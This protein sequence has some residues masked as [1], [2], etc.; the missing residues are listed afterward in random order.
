MI[1][2]FDQRGKVTVL[3]L[4]VEI[5]TEDSHQITHPPLRLERNTQLSLL[6]PLGI[7]KL[8][9]LNTYEMSQLVPGQAFL[10]SC[11]ISLLLSCTSLPQ[12]SGACSTWSFLT[13]QERGLCQSSFLNIIHKLL[14]LH[15][16]LSAGHIVFYISSSSCRQTKRPWNRQI[17]CQSLPPEVCRNENSSW[18]DKI[19]DESVWGNYVKT[20]VNLK[21]N[22][23]WL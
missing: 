17:I 3:S 19:S 21:K 12:T 8:T 14:L 18:S 22:K 7:I 9:L 6:T 1:Y 13:D 20:Y 16:L 23:L 2:L 15:I 4:C 11:P 5:L 10:K